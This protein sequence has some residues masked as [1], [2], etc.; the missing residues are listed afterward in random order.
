MRT[1]SPIVNIPNLEIFSGEI[2]AIAG[3]SGIGRY[4]TCS[5]IAGLIRPISGSIKVC[6]AGNPLRLLSVAH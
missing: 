5:T 4:F 2:V 6:G 3:P 1:E